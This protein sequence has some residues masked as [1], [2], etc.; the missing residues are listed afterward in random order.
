MHQA[1]EMSGRLLDLLSHVIVAIK[2]EDVGDQ[3]QSILIVLNFGVE[4]G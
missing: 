4:A 1:V 2:V 3:V